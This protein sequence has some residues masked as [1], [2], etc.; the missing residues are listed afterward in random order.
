MDDALKLIMPPKHYSLSTEERQGYLYVHLASETISEEIIR[1]Y[2][3]EMVEASERTHS[4]RIM[5]YRD[6]PAV[7]TEG[8]VFHTVSDSL[9]AFR[10]RKL[11]LV[12]PY[13]EIMK[14]L[15]FGMTVGQNR[16]GN[17]AVFEST[18]EAE[19]WLLA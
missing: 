1:G 3:A 6:I 10:G 11:A 2:V 9:Q 15:K 5:L 7:M 16:G 18:S 14:E 13:P 12:N 4:D 19:E 8:E 17:Y